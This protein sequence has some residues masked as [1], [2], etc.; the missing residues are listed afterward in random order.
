MNSLAPNLTEKEL[1]YLELNTREN[2]LC[3]GLIK[4]TKLINNDN[5]CDLMPI[6]LLPTP[7]PRDKYLLAKEIQ[8]EINLISHRIAYDNQFLHESLEPICKI[9]DLTN[10]LFGI[11]E[12]VIKTGRAQDKSLGLFRSDYMLDE[13]SNRLLQVEVNAI[14][15]GFAG[16]TPLLADLHKENLIKCGIQFNENNLPD[17][18]PSLELAR[19]LETGVHAYGDACCLNVLF[20]V[21]EGVKNLSDQKQIE[22][23]LKQLNPKINSIRRSFKQLDDELRLDEN[24]RLF[25]DKLEIA[26]V[27]YR[28]GYSP[29]DYTENNIKTRTKIELSKGERLII[30]IKNN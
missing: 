9:D 15:V 3:N 8:E 28:V 17:K 12:N 4:R 18:I 24:R 6:T 20:L 1:F 22:F 5:I 19:G 29:E 16:L 23:K 21:E 10:N 27:Y 13:M 7:F 26:V 30:T 2:A 14:S 11:Y 25:V